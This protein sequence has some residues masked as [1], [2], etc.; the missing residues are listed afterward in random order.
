MYSCTNVQL[1]GPMLDKETVKRMNKY[2]DLGDSYSSDGCPLIE[3]LEKAKTF[4]E[5]EDIKECFDRALE[6]ECIN[7]R[8]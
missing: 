3:C 8:S 1:L 2:S 6:L 7:R 4:I 5:E